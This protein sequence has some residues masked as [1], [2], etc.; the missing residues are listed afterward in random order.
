MVLGD[1]STDLE[2]RFGVEL[3]LVRLNVFGRDLLDYVN[4]NGFAPTLLTDTM[5]MNDGYAVT[6]V[7]T[8]NGSSEA[9]FITADCVS[10][11]GCSSDFL[12]FGI[13]RHR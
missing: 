10:S 1:K 3:R 12:P 13:R 8:L 5:E 9:D 2:S 11:R 7:E 6:D 4:T